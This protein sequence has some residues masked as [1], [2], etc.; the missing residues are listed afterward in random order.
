MNVRSRGRPTSSTVLRGETRAERSEAERGPYRGR[1][2]ERNEAQREDERS[3]NR[4]RR[5]VG[6]VAGRLWR[7]G[8]RLRVRSAGVVR[9]SRIIAVRS[10]ITVTLTFPRGL[11]AESYRTRLTPAGDVGIVGSPPSAFGFESR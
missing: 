10:T 5:A 1:R 11:M 4:P 8:D 3:A 6:F 9:I 7:R 2:A